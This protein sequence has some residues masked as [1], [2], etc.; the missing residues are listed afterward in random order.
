MQVTVFLTNLRPSR[1]VSQSPTGGRGWIKPGSGEF[2]IGRKEGSGHGRPILDIQQALK[3]RKSPKLACM[4]SFADGIGRT[5]RQPDR[6]KD[7]KKVRRELK[8]KDLFQV[9]MFVP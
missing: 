4:W 1:S 7:G 6:Q 3:M 9:D 8:G 2:A 5:D